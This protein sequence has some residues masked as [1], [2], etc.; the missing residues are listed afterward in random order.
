MS[1]VVASRI[2]DLLPPYMSS[3]HRLNIMEVLWKKY[4][5][6]TS[7]SFRVS[8]NAS[9]NDLTVAM[10]EYW[11]SMDIR[12][13][14]PD[15]VSRMGAWLTGNDAAKGQELFNHFKELDKKLAIE[16][17]RVIF[18][19][20]GPR[21]RVNEG[22]NFQATH[23]VKV[24]GHEA[25]LSFSRDESNP[26]VARSKSGSSKPTPVES[27]GDSGGSEEPGIIGWIILNGIVA[28]LVKAC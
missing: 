9:E 1:G 20:I 7:V 12:H 10:E 8:A 19:T 15:T 2:F 26:P 21:V 22:T 11:R 27:N 17:C 24:G 23:V 6:R 25:E 14:L 3:S 13:Q 4:S 5:P 18:K 16:K 28:L